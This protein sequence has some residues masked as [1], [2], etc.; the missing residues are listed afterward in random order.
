MVDKLEAIEQHILEAAEI[1]F[2]WGVC[3][4]GLWVESYANR[5]GISFHPY[6]GQYSTEEEARE[7]IKKKPVADILDENFTRTLKPIRG[8]ICM[9]DDNLALG[10]VMGQK[11]AFKAN[12]RGVVVRDL[13]KCCIFWSI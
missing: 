6:I 10:I 5:L 13:S 8:D 2:R 11:A 12:R 9:L 3:D 1:N 4:C 7:L